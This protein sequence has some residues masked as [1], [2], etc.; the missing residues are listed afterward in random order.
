MDI[1]AQ[2]HET[3]KQDQEHRNIIHNS[4]SMTKESNSKIHDYNITYFMGEPTFIK[5]EEESLQPL[6]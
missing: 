4:M 2:S 1:P 3:R 5:D 6:P